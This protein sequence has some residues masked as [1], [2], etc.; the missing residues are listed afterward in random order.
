MKLITLYGS[1]NSGKSALLKEVI[2]H[3]KS[4]LEINTAIDIQEIFE[5]KI[6]E[7]VL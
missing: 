1:A 6:V 4:D 7:L 5:Y 3:F 2:K